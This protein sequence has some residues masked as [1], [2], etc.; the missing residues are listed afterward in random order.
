MA[1]RLPREYRPIHP[2]ALIASAALALVLLLS[3]W[4]LS[5]TGCH[6][7]TIAEGQGWEL[8]Q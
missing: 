4:R 5:G 1:L 3:F 7:A 6:F 2:G 8:S